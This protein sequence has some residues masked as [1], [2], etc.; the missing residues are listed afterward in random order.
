MPK[1]LIR[2]KDTSKA[3]AYGENNFSVVV[4]GYVDEDTFDYEIAKNIEI[5]KDVYELNSVSDFEK[6]IGKTPGQAI[7]AKNAEPEIANAEVTGIA[8][9]Q[10]KVKKEDFESEE[11]GV[12]TATPAAP[13]DTRIGSYGP[14][15]FQLGE[16]TYILTKVE[17]NDN[18]FKEIDSDPDGDGVTEKFRSEET[19]LADYLKVY[20]DKLG[21][22]AKSP[23]QIGNQI[24]YELLN[25]GYTVLFKKI[26]SYDAISELS[27]ASFWEQLKDRSI[28][29]FRY[30]LSGLRGEYADA[31]VMR[32]IS[33]IATF[34]QDIAKDA[35][36]Q[37]VLNNSDV[38]DA[39]HGRGDCIALCDIDERDLI[40][41]TTDEEIVNGISTSV[42][43]L[44][45]ADKYTAIFGPQVTYNMSEE[46]VRAF[47]G[48]KT[49]PASFHYLACAASAFKR[50]SE[51]YAVAGYSRGQ[52]ARTVDSTSFVLGERVINTLAPR[53]INEKYNINKAVNLVLKE[54]GSYYLWGNRTAHALDDKGLVYSHFLNIRQLCTTIKKQL[55]TAC[56]KFTFD[57]N[58]DLLWINFVNA[59][60]PTLEAM[61]ADYGIKGYK[62]VQK[63]D[64]TK[65]V[66]KAVIRIIP[67]EAVEDFDL[68]INLEEDLAGITANVVE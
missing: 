40:N 17:Y 45:S 23:Y 65:A 38:I 51:W 54:R 48:N 13:K 44:S 64:N 35:E 32:Q 6:Y 12:Y 62:I 3:N 52:A 33:S 9:Y 34:N 37:N 47:G 56:R 63:V 43:K 49:F 15:I 60:K 50:F 1:I 53:V 31:S 4:P 46:E 28:Y 19:E 41:C 55:Y 8:K 61:R 20:N 68:T 58:S 57:P 11:Y 25:L 22:A 16:I 18:L 59:I 66:L 7:P 14:G 27:S 21:Q 26:N 30:I 39:N 29:N 36:M 24:A 2:E 5:G 42:G 10:G 67:I